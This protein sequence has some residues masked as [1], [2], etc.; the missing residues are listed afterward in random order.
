MAF[1]RPDMTLRALSAG[2]AGKCLVEA[3]MLTFRWVPHKLVCSSRD[4]DF[5]NLATLTTNCE[6]TMRAVQIDTFGNSD[7]LKIAEVPTPVIGSSEVLVRVRAAGVNFADALLRRD[8]YAYTPQL[9]T[10]LGSEVAGTVEAFGD[11]VTEFAEG[12]RVAAPLFATSSPSGGYAEYVVIDA[13]WLV[14]LPDAITFEDAAALM[15][16]GL[17]ASFLIE[18]S[19][20]RGKKVLIN[21]A[22]GGVGSMLI[23]LARDAG[24]ASVVAAASSLEKLKLAEQLGATGSVNYRENN[25]IE[26]VRTSSGEPDVIFESAG[27]DITRQSLELLGTE[28]SMIIYG[29][30][31]IQEF[32]LGVPELLRLIFKNQSLTG[33]ALSPLLSPKSLRARLSS[34]FDLVAQRRLVVTIG[35]TFP[36]E[37]VAAAHR[38]LE[39][40]ASIGKLVLVP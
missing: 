20:V 35:G 40:R 19:S 3:V 32:E 6:S 2:R 39:S 13:S 7:V 33:F 16:T 30:L 5:R 18:R 34:L 17:T 28:G 11:E 10:V 29:A 1:Q 12:Q 26:Q 14:S 21:A 37:E 22:A 4:R 27:G 24:A 31:N 9:P 8:S 38:L 23:Q 36:L 15:V 25:W